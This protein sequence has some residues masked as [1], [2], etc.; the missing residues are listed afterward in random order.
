M[1]ELRETVLGDPAELPGRSLGGRLFGGLL[2][3]LALA[4]C[5][6]GVDKALTAA[7]VNGVQ[8]TLTVE[9]CWMQERSGRAFDEPRCSGRFRPDGGGEPVEN[10]EYRGGGAANVAVGQELEVHRSGATYKLSGG[11]GLA[12]G[13]MAVSG[14]LAFSALAVPFLATGIQPRW[15]GRGQNRTRVLAMVTFGIKGTTAGRVRNALLLVGLVGMAV[16]YITFGA[17]S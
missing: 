5:G 9:R 11:R 2:L 7:K 16:S 8:G 1:T 10:A 4:I 15:F 14:G 6:A 12:Q 17:M 3:L 13:V